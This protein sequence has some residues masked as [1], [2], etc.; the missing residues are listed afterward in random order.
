MEITT[1]RESDEKATYTAAPVNH[2]VAEP[3]SSPNASVREPERRKGAMFV[4][5]TLIVLLG[6]AIIYGMRS[7]ATAE[8][9]LKRSTAAAAIPFVNVIH[10]SGGSAAQEIVLPGNTQ[11]FTDTPIYARTN[12]YLK[13]WYVDIG[14]HV[15]KGQLLAEIETPELDQQLQQAEAD[16]KSAEA[17]MQLAQ[18]TSVRWQSLLEKHAVSKQETDQMVSDYAARQA[19]YAASQA[20]VRRLKELQGYEHVTAP[21]DGTI[22]ARNTDIGALIGTGS[23]AAPRELFHLAAVG[24]LRIYV[25]VPEVYADSVRDGEKV[26][27]TQDADPK[28]VITGTISRNSSAIDQTS[29]T[30]NVQVD[31]DNSKGQLLPGAYVFVHLKLPAASHTVTIPSNT[32]LFR[33]EGLRVG[34]VRDGVVQLA[35]I[36][37]GH[38]FGATVEVTSGL[39]SNDTI[40]LD[41]S[42]SLTSGTKV[43]VNAPQQKGAE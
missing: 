37:I 30:L 28:T 34:V 14:S 24:R 11:A 33:A 20:N 17:N 10:P 35:P 22:T 42:D 1:T 32:L 36:T 23:G 41:P 7:R 26:S 31:V 39:T 16:L 21:F 2:V 40:V 15:R 4:G 27:I 9:D 38:D 8:D 29:R 5:I 19:N 3:P 43:E 12:G 6:G 18:T 25:A 13:R